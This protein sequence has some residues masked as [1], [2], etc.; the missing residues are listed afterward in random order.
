MLW[1]KE[2]FQKFGISNY[3]LLQ[4]QH[5]LEVCEENGYVTPTCYQGMY[6]VISRKVEEIFPLLDN[7]DIEF[8]AY[9]PLAGGL[10]TGKYTINSRDKQSRFKNNSIYQNIFWK[11]TIMQKMIPFFEQGVENCTQQ[12][13]EWLQHYSKMRLFDKIIL[14]ASTEEQLINNIHKI[15]TR[16]ITSKNLYF[17][18]K[19]YSHIEHVSPNYYY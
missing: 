14:G 5:L 18:N 17:I 3:S 6:N 19:L 15:G 16:K 10:L 11:P 4:T 13:F 8:W 9:N 12:S 2:K 1:R 7:Y